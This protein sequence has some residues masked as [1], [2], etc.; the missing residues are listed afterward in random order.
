MS[1]FKRSKEEVQEMMDR[2]IVANETA[3]RESDWGPLADFYAEDAE[4]SY[5]MGE[6]G[7]RVCRGREA[8]R[9]YVMGKDMLGF[10][11]WVFPYEWVVIDGDRVM[12][13]WWNQA[14]QKRDDG[15]PYRVVGMSAITVND[16]LQIQTMHD[17]FDLQALQSMCREI[18]R[19]FGSRKEKPIVIRSSDSSAQGVVVLEAERTS[20][21]THVRFLNLGSPDVDGWNVTG[22]VTFYE[23]P[24]QSVGCEFGANRCEDALNVIRTSFDIDGAIF[25]DT[26]SDAFDSDF[27]SGTIRR[28]SFLRC[29]NDGIDISGSTVAVRDVSV[30]GAGDKAISAGEA[31]RMTMSEI[32][33][34]KANI[35]VASKDQCEVEGQDVVIHDTKIGLTAF[36]KKSE[37][38]PA[39]LKV[40]QLVLQGVETPSLVETG[41]SV[42]VDGQ[43]QIEN[44]TDLKGMLY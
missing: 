21:L 14:P 27:C 41:S 36:R 37:F 29:G 3:E 6:Q 2:W 33:I 20:Y 10:E 30:D 42:V 19:K 18:N 12:T 28:S 31:S 15:S 40:R 1:E 43:E 24:L 32:R 25:R 35:G 34:S 44:G 5:T 23:S 4:Y 17:N 9:D 38:G 26:Y 39:S 7:T 16:D 8:V 22:A 13:K 11:D